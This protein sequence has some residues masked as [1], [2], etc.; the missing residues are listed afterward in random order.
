MMIMYV[1]HTGNIVDRG[2][3]EIVGKFSV[4]QIPGKI[5]AL[6]GWSLGINK[7]SQKYEESYRFIRWASCSQIAVPFTVL[8]GCT[9]RSMVNRAEELLD[10]YPYLSLAEKSFHK[11]RKRTFALDNLSGY[12]I[13]EKGF[14]KVLSM[15]IEKAVKGQLTCERA[16]EEISD[17]LTQKVKINF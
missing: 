8:G 1:N 3:S 10:L 4:A 9:P 11:S 16:I 15:Y 5:P 17:Y 2:Y 14:D 13:D 7:A 12:G 6:D